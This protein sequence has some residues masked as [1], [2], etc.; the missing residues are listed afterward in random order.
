MR[1]L[2]V[3]C[4]IYS[5]SKKLYLYNLYS[6]ISRRAYPDPGFGTGTASVSLL[7]YSLPFP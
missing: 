5:L 2:L 3:Y 1:T 4:I 6:L 7:C